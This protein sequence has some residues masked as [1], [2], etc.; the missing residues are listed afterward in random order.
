MEWEMVV[1][2]RSTELLCVVRTKLC[3]SC[4]Q[5]Y[6]VHSCYIHTC[7]ESDNAFCFELYIHTKIFCTLLY[8]HACIESCFELY[9]VVN[10]SKNW[11]RN[12]GKKQ[13][14]EKRGWSAYKPILHY[15]GL[16]HTL[17]PCVIETTYPLTK[18]NESNSCIACQQHILTLY[19]SVKYVSSV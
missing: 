9:A 6:F 13:F 5:E 8:I 1:E 15:R 2:I 7:I 14:W 16:L 11:L 4:S 18:V 19:V 3:V 17:T 12:T 10:I